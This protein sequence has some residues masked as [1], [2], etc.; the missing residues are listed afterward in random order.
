MNEEKVVSI[1]RMH[2]GPRMSQVVTHAGM[3]YLAGQVAQ[4]A[5]G[6]SV[7]EQTRDILARIDALLAEAGSDKS[8]ILTATIWLA[9]MGTYAQMNEVWDAWVDSA[10][11]PAR[12]CVESRLAAPGY[13]VEIQVTAVA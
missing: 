11:P 10:H 3:V 6:A 9:N 4:G 13:T 8:K 1:E 5:V 2:K 12:A 7:V